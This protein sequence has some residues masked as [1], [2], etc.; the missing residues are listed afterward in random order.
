MRIEVWSDVVCPWCYIGKR[1]LE[2][3]LAQLPTRDGIDIVHRSFQL[4]P[5][6]AVGETSSRRAMLMGKYRLSAS[7]VEAMDDRMEQTAVADGLD[8][9]LTEKSLTGNTARAHAV[10]HLARERGIQDA[11]IERFFRAYFTEE[12]SIFDDDALVALAAEAGLDGEDVRRALAEGTFT[13]AVRSEGDK[14]RSLGATGVPFFVIDG[15]LGISG[16]QPVRVFVE[17]LQQARA[18]ATRG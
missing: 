4:N 7:Q 10:L 6:A 14:A 13:D 12:R 18:A 1:R 17:A 3:A 9:R 15:R 16:A 8:F 11:V 2:H 5:A